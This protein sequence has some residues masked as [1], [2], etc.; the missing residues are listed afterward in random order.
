MTHFNLLETII[1]PL[2]LRGELELDQMVRILK[3]SSNFARVKAEMIFFLY[4][5]K[6]SALQLPSFGGRM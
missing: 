6:K 1:I 2:L 4:L 5:N 3:G